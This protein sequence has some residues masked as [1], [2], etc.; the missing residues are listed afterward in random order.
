MTSVSAINFTSG[1][2]ALSAF[3]KN[4]ATIARVKAIFFMGFLRGQTYSFRCADI[5]RRCHVRA[6]ILSRCNQLG[7]P[8]EDCGN[9]E[10]AVDISGTS[11]HT[12]L[13]VGLPF[14]WTGGPRSLTTDTMCQNLFETIRVFERGWIE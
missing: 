10:S 7:L 6:R 3:G 14:C 12:P 13:A 11:W 5:A 1:L 2:C 9:R 4:R 8:E